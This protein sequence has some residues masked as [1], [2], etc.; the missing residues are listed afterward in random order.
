MQIT[1]NK[2]AYFISVKKDDIKIKIP[3][4]IKLIIIQVLRFPYITKEYFS[5]KGAKYDI[6]IPIKNLKENGRFI[7]LN[8]TIVAVSG[9][10]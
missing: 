7:E 8:K 6:R 9:S 2:L 4:I 10:V 3:D 5:K 1:A